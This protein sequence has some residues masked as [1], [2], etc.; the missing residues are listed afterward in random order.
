MRTGDFELFAKLVKD[1]SG[2]YLTADKAYLIESR[3]MAVARKHSMRNLEDL[4]DALRRDQ[5]RE[6]AK[7]ITEAMTTNE[8]SFFRDQRPFEQFRT[9]LLPKLLQTRRERRLIRIWSA[10]CSSGQEP[11]SLAMILHEEQARLAGWKVEIMA[12]DIS[13]EMVDRAKLGEFSQFE[14]QRGLPIQMLVRY[15][16]QRGDKWVV[17]EDIRNR[18]TF[19]TFNLMDDPGTL[20]I[21]DVIFCRNVLIYFDHETKAKVLEKLSR[22]MPADGVLFLGGAETIIGISD[23]FK[24]YPEQRGMFN[25]IKNGPPGSNMLINQHAEATG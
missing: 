13:A 5:S 22:R 6:L 20:G 16:D 3:L 8:S 24:S 25:V 17:K 14:V 18:I 12:T 11:F 19:K 9:V 4:A 10:A 2:I 15:F 23:R 21:F 7:D 1:A